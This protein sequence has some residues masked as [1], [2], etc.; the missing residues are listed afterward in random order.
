MKK[1][2]KIFLLLVYLELF[3]QA[4]SYGKFVVTKRKTY[5][6]FRAYDWQAAKTGDYWWYEESVDIHPAFRPYVNYIFSDIATAHIHIDA[7]G[8]RRT[9]NNPAIT[10]TVKKI[11]MFGGSTLAGYGVRDD[12]TIPSYVA[13]AVNSK[14]P[15]HQISNYGQFAYN[16]SQSLMFLQLQ[17]K[18][19][20]IPDLV[21][22]YEGANDYL[23]AAERLYYGTPNTIYMEADMRNRIDP[24]FTT[25]HV[26]TSQS[27][28]NN[29][30]FSREFLST[31]AGGVER[32]V[33]L[34][35]Y[36][37]VLYRRFADSGYAKPR[38]N[39]H[40]A[41]AELDRAA[42]TVADTVSANARIIDA[43][44]EKYH[45]SYLILG[46]PILPDKVPA[47]DEL[48]YTTSDFYRV[49]QT[50]LKIIRQ[51]TA[52]SGIRNYASVADTFATYP[53]RSVFIDQN[54][55]TAEGNAIIAGRIA[56]IIARD[57]QLGSYEGIPGMTSGFREK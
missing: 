29:S 14:K 27:V 50:L 1:S 11:F 42:Q 47:T 40:P 54:H 37:L 34:V 20:N 56:E 7:D 12:E 26:F 52:A 31:L 8:M 25:T 16:S 51:K 30:I 6:E 23:Q 48:P 2:V 28:I 44:A 45:F 18:K 19:N 36:P 32:Y 15:G 57:A 3:L 21:V 24:F 35:H 13:K 9:A 39:A 33:K 22:F 10:E 53:Q 5:D 38:Y 55:L 17:L 4:V 43:L 41:P 46:Q 49:S